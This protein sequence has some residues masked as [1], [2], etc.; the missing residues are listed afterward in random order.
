MLRNSL[1][2]LVLCLT[3][4][5]QQEEPVRLDTTSAQEQ[6]LAQ[7]TQPVYQNELDP[8]ILN[9]AWW[10]EQ[11]PVVQQLLGLELGQAGKPLTLSELEDRFHQTLMANAAKANTCPGFPTANP[12]G[13]VTLNSQADVDAFGALNCKTVIGALEIIDTLGPDPICDLMPLR[14]LKEVG[15]SLTINANCLSSLAGLGKL[16]SVGEL[17]PFGF[18]GVLGAN[19]TDIDALDKL[20]TVTG[21]INI[22]ECD[23]LTSVNGAFSRIT[24]IESGKSAQPLTSIFVLNINGNDLL[25]DLSAFSGLTKIEG[26]LRILTN[27]ALLDLDDFSGLNTIGDDIFIFENAALQNVN[28]LSNISSLNDDLFVFDNPSL[29][30]CCGLYSLLCSDA[31]TCSANGVGDGIAIFNNGAGCTEIDITTNGPC[32]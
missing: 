1:L 10:K 6:V 13:N 11:N 5:C 7:A 25:T 22:I 19:L 32:L 24:T 3:L 9:S 15:S 27:A 17:G 23:A 30:E 29:T 14:K 21:S 18:V 28:E 26:G 4:A 2:F 20:A 16:K 8:S 12:E 31:P